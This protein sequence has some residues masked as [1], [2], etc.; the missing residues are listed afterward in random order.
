MLA[1]Q[2]RIVIADLL[3]RH[4][5]T[6]EFKSLKRARGRFMRILAETLRA[7]DEIWV[8]LDPMRKDPGKGKV[9]R[10]YPAR[11]SWP[12]MDAPGSA[13]LEWTNN[14]WYGVTTF[15]GARLRDLER[16][17]RGVLPYRREN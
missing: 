16:R 17:R 4:T 8:S 1:R 12:G 3:P 15:Q 2:A 7:P 5:R 10:R 6:G 13:V 11:F 9:F 14:G